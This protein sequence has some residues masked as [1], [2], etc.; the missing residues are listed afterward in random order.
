MRRRRLAL[1]V[2]LLLG[3]ASASKSMPG[4]EE[5]PAPGDDRA[6][7]AN[8][9]AAAAASDPAA[10]KISGD[11]RAASDP[12]APSEP[13]P[14][15][16]ASEPAP[17]AQPA[18]APPAKDPLPKPLHA[19]V[20]GSCGKGPG[21]GQRLKSFNLK[22]TKGKSVSSGSLKGKVAVVN[23]WGTW[24]KPCLKELPE[25]D[26]LHR[27]YRKHGMTLVAIATD[28]DPAPVDEFVGK[29]HLSAKVLIGGEDYANGFS[30]D[31]F[32]FT[33]VVDPKGIIRASYRGYRP[34]CIG[35]LEADVRKELEE[36]G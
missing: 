27:R 28:T 18:A 31:K 8:D 4:W 36:R 26:Q 12:V 33:F 10:A 24:C 25:F 7:A 34:E 14:E 11:D 5:S 35:K 30:P 23:F 15:P 21:V 17:P 9:P 29:H 19:K 32:P 3:C 13:P 22:T 6:M 20:D 2:S 16:T 1:H